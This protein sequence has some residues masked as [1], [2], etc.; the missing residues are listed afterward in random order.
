MVDVWE[1]V[2]SKY[3]KEYSCSEAEAR[4]NAKAVWILDWCVSVCVCLCEC[5]FFL[6]P[7]NPL[8]QTDDTHR[9]VSTHSKNEGFDHI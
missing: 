4:N 3:M 6:L 1:E 7:M 8:I 9:V 5:V 2:V